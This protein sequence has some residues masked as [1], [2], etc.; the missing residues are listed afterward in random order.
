[1]WLFCREINARRYDESELTLKKVTKRKGHFGLPKLLW[2]GS[3]YGNF[4]CEPRGSLTAVGLVGE[5]TTQSVLIG[6]GRCSYKSIDGAAYTTNIYFSQ[7][8]RLVPRDPLRT[9]GPLPGLRCILTWQR[10]ERE[11]AGSLGSPSRR[12]LVPFVRGLFS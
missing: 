5:N 6:L 11:E 1:M 12:T 4:V 10:A 7:F 2:S 9:E 3:C 8:C